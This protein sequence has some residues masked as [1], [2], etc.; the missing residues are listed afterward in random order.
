MPKSFATSSTQKLRKNTKTSIL[1]PFYFIKCNSKPIRHIHV[2][3]VHVWTFYMF[4]DCS[5]TGKVPFSD[6]SCTWARIGE[7]WLKTCIVVTFWDAILCVLLA[8]KYTCTHVTIGNTDLSTLTI[9][10]WCSWFQGAS[11]GLM[12]RSL[13]FVIYHG[14]ST[15]NGGH[16]PPMVDTPEH[17]TYS[18][19]SV[20][21][22]HCSCDGA[23]PV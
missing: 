21:T 2:H 20:H 7:L 17:I 18:D 13:T 15:S 22:V 4:N 14:L 23:V 6:Q 11:H 3:I 9:W 10:L 12:A 5:T 8:I 1:L 19:L 16:T